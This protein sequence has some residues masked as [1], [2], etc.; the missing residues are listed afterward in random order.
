MP[1]ALF[2]GAVSGFWEFWLH[3]LAKLKLKPFHLLQA[4]MPIHINGK[5]AGN[6]VVINESSQ[7]DNGECDTHTLPIPS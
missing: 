6:P 5:G 2:W 3:V 4:V 1:N 7:T